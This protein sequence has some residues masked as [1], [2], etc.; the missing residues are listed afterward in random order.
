MKKFKYY[1]NMIVSLPVI[2]MILVRYQNTKIQ[3]QNHINIIFGIPKKTLVKKIVKFIKFPNYF[4]LWV[5]L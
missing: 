4:A 3:Y 2:F 1:K 5:T